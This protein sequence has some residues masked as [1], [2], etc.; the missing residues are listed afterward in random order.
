MATAEGPVA[1]Y[2][3]FANFEEKKKEIEPFDVISKNS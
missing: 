1:E 3:S 2:S